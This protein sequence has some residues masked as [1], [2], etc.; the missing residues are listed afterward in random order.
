MDSGWRLNT[1]KK[2]GNRETSAFTVCTLWHENN[3]FKNVL[4]N[5]FKT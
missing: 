2:A 1:Q 5:N 4:L 3:D